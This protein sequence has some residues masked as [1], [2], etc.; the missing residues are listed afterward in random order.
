MQ[1]KLEKKV[2]SNF[3][4]SLIAASSMYVQVR[5]GWELAEINK[6]SPMGKGREHSLSVWSEMRKKSAHFWLNLREKLASWYLQCSS[7]SICRPQ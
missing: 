2:A 5:S 4:N 1:E 3:Q 6:K 7:D